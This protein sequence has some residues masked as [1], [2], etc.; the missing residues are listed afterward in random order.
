MIVIRK[1]LWCLRWLI[2]GLRWSQ[3][4]GSLGEDRVQTVHRFGPV[5]NESDRRSQY[6]EY[7]FDWSGLDASV[8]YVNDYV[9]AVWFSS[10]KKI[11]PEKV[12]EI[13]GFYSCGKEWIEVEREDAWQSKLFAYYSDRVYGLWERSDGSAWAICAHLGEEGEDDYSCHLDVFSGDWMRFRRVHYK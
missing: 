6:P 10:I 5:V 13:L 9:A 3:R 11:D 2:E 7:E 8:R 12:E 1:I 4:R